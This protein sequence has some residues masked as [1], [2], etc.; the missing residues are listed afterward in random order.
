MTAQRIITLS[1]VVL[2]IIVTKKRTITP[3]SV[4]SA[5]SVLVV[6]G[7]ELDEE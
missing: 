3:S 6:H 1:Y 5:I 7:K 2:H 4:L